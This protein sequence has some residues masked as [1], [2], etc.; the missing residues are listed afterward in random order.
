MVQTNSAG[1]A[2]YFCSAN[3]SLGAAL[4][5]AIDRHGAVN[6]GSARGLAIGAASARRA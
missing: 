5:T 3:P 4:G 6:H 1:K 2:N